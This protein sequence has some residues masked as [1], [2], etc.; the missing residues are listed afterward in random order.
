MSLSASLGA[1][2]MDQFYRGAYFRLGEAL[3]KYSGHVTPEIIRVSSS[4]PE[5]GRWSP[6]DIA[7]DLIQDMAAFAWPKLGYR[8][9][10]MPAPHQHTRSVWFVTS[11]RSAMRGLQERHVKMDCLPQQSLLGWMSTPREYLPPGEYMKAVFYPKFTPFGQALRDMAE[12]KALGCAL[13]EDFALCI[14][15]SQGHGIKFDVLYRG[16]IVGHVAENGEAVLPVRLR[17]RS[18]VHTLFEGKV[19]V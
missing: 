8:E 2:Y 18:S 9:Y 16:N 5:V 7:T 4:T 12:G 11:M 6:R 13:S 3:C 10:N 19:R 14:S 1:E 17:K 15:V